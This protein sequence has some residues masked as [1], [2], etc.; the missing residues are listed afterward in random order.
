MMPSFSSTGASAGRAGR[1]GYRSVLRLVSAAKNT[2]I[3]VSRQV[4]PMNREM[5]VV[6]PPEAA[7]SEA[8]ISGVKPPPMVPAIW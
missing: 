1:R 3:T 4:A 7:S 5:P 8:Q 6:P 2:A